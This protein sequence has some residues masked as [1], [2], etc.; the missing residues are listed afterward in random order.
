MNLYYKHTF[1]TSINS[2]IN[3]SISIDELNS[4]TSFHAL[5]VCSPVLTVL[6]SWASVVIWGQWTWSGRE[7]WGGGGSGGKST[8]TKARIPDSPTT[9][10]VLPTEMAA[11]LPQQRGTTCKLSGCIFVMYRECPDWNGSETCAVVCRIRRY[12]RAYDV[13][14][15]PWYTLILSAAFLYATLLYRSVGE[16]YCVSTTLDFV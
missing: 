5:R 16:G 2:S 6:V 10:S 13:R 4:T 7:K 12:G 1:F 9:E 14:I 8:A 11:I 3:Q 15:Y